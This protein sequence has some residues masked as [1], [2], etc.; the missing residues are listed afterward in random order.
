MRSADKSDTASPPM[1]VGSTYY[2]VY[3]FPNITTLTFLMGCFSHRGNTG[4]KSGRLIGGKMS[5]IIFTQ[6]IKSHN[7]DK[8][9]A[10]ARPGSLS[11]CAQ[12]PE[13]AEQL[14]D[15]RVAGEERLPVHLSSVK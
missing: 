14:V 9:P 10:D 1:L 6:C 4:L 2:Q 13:Y 5:I 15:L 3:I 8:L 11:G 12:L 7:F